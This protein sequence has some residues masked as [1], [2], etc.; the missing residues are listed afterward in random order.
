MVSTGLKEPT[1]PFTGELVEMLRSVESKMRIAVCSDEPYEIH[2][3]VV[4]EIERL[5]HEVVRFGSLASGQDESWVNAARLAAESIAF[6]GC[7]EGIF[8]CFQTFFK[9]S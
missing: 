3:L 5:G 9:F 1:Q 2:D 6:G 4:E 8:F 7:D